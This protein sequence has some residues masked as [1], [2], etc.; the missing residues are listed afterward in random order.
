M[1]SKHAFEFFR[2]V[3]ARLTIF[4]FKSI[5][6]RNSLFAF[7]RIFPQ[8]IIVPCMWTSDVFTSA[9]GIFDKYLGSSFCI[10]LQRVFGYQNG[11]KL[12][13]SSKSLRSSNVC[14]RTEQWWRILTVDLSLAEF[15]SNKEK[16]KEYCKTRK[17]SDS[18]YFTISFLA[19]HKKPVKSSNMPGKWR[20]GYENYVTGKQLSQ[21]PK[22]MTVKGDTSAVKYFSSFGQCLLSNC[23][24]PEVDSNYTVHWIVRNV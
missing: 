3:P 13:V 22:G 19:G 7:G 18:I 21:T 1:L 11:V 8:A 12:S 15:Y 2:V 20:F 23:F 16:K 9:K 5:N 14:K 6:D 17:L 24:G 4:L 10:V